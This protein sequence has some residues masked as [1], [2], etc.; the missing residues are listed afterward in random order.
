L[1]QLTGRLRLSGAVTLLLIVTACG[2]DES[3]RG[4]GDGPDTGSVELADLDARQLEKCR[5]V[6]FVRTACPE[7]VPETDARYLG[8]SIPFGNPKFRTF[9][10]GAS[11]PYEGQ[12][13]R[14]RPPRFAH[15]VVAAGDLAQA[16]EFKWPPPRSTRPPERLL[17][18]NRKRPVLLEKPTWGGRDGQLVLL[19][20]FPLGGI[21]GDHLAFRWRDAGVDYV[22]SLHAWAPFSEA[23]ATLRAMVE[24][25]A[26]PST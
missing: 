13:R 8:R 19:H 24:E 15:I 9:D 5:S 11:A 7:V 14:N 3:P 25:L 17:F 16:F 6:R 1:L 2:P 10:L 26:P 21:H 4:L 20:P 22:L 18:A 12:P 23:R